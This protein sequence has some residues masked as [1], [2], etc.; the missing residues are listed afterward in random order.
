MKKQLLALVL[1]AAVTFSTV[2]YNALAFSTEVTKVKVVQGVNFRTQPSTTSGEKIRLLRVGELLD[3]VS[4]YNSSWLL[5]RDASG[6]V[7]YVS[8]SSTYVRMTTVQVDTEPNA[9]VA[10]SVSFRTGPSTNDSRI[11]YL[12]E[13]E[14]LLV[15]ERPN[16]YWYKV[17]DANDV[18]GYV[19]SSSQYITTTFEGAAE[20]AV[21]EEPTESLFQ[22][23]PNATALSSV[24][25][26]SAPST[27]SS[28]IRYLAKGEKLL[29]LNKTNNYWYNVQDQ[30][31]VIGYVSTGSQY[32]STTFVEP[33][34]LLDP[35]VAAQK[36]IDAGM[37]YIGVP[38]EFGS[39][40]YD[41]STFDC[42]DFVR[43][44]FLDGTGQLLPGDSRSQGS[45]V[46][47]VG[48]TSGDWKQLKAGDLMFFMSYKGSSAASYTGIDKTTE[49][50][51]HVG[52]YLGDGR[53]LHTYSI[54]SGGV[55]IDTIAGSQW[56]KRFL[57]GGST[58]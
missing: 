7:G 10:A 15:L 12:A 17:Q 47:S 57:F 33:Y 46:Q 52:I 26:R 48:K 42:S 31:G 41:L 4:V 21:E 51:T 45:Y 5:V 14:K 30:N 29:I 39:N 43:Q 18:V 22:S 53:M 32:I 44:S 54:E 1:G 3:L 13:G 11:R 6:Q 25:F 9:E 56:E 58:Y 49:T 35:A 24:S 34:K 23:E 8:D 28:R 50:I 37:K 16:A 40:R 38:Y 36:V 27:D 20:Q 2:P 19:S 55:R